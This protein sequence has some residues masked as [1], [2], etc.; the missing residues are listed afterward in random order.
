[1]AERIG[2]LI[3]FKIDGISQ[4]AKGGFTYNLGIPKKEMVKGSDQVHGY[5]EEP[6]IPFIEGSITDRGSLDLPALQN[7]VNVTCVLELANGKIISLKD[8]V[9]ASEGNVTTDEGEIELRMEGV[10]AEEIR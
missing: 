9:Y 6:Q 1:M 2:G 4:F 5:K 10:S 8:A 7:A 3:R